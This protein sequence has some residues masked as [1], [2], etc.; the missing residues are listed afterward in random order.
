M[1]QYTVLSQQHHCMLHIHTVR[2]NSTLSIS[3]PHINN[4]QEVAEYMRK[5][6]LPCHVIPNYT[7]VPGKATAQSAHPEY[8]IETGCQIKFGSHHPLLINP[9]F[10]SKLKSTFQLQ[11][12]HLEVEG[13]FKG[14]IYDYFTVSKCPPK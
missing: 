10:W 7:V 4:C 12:A 1:S 3:S 9:L 6:Q 2:D 5:C 11:C 8:T 14:C 13:K